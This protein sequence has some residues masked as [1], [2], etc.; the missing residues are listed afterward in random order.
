MVSLGIDQVS[1]RIMSVRDRHAGGHVIMVVMSV[2][3]LSGSGI[4]SQ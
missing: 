2:I 3:D 1:G 4:G